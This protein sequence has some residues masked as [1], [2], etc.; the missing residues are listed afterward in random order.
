VLIG[1]TI[2]ATAVVRENRTSRKDPER[3]VVTFACE[4]VNQHKKAVMTFDLLQLM[5]ARGEPA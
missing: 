3:A 5:R 2:R 4:V 1:D